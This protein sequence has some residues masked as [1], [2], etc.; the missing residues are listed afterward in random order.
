MKEK[1][2]ES[3]ESVTDEETNGSDNNPIVEPSTDEETN[4]SDT[5]LI[6]TLSLNPLLMFQFN[7]NSMN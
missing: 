1:H 4:G 2:A 3:L 7:N 6:I 5:V